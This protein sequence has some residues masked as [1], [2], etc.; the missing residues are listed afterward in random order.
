MFC[1][2]YAIRSTKTTKLVK[3]KNTSVGLNVNYGFVDDD[4][5]ITKLLVLLICIVNDTVFANSTARLPVT[6]VCV[7]AFTEPN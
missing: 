4:S 1:I 2:F 6:F 7:F 5:A 3:K